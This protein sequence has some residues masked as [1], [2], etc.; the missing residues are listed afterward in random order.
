MF[1]AFLFI[2]LPYVAILALIVGTAYRAHKHRFTNTALTSQFLESRSLMWGAVA[3]HAG[4][5]VVLAGHAVAILMPDLWLALTSNYAFLVTV[6]VIGIAAAMLALAGLCVL[7]V[8]RVLHARL[9]RVS[10]VMDFAV[11]GLLIAQVLLGLAVAVSYRWGAVWS[12]QTAT[13]YLWSLVRL[14]PDLA[15]AAAMPPVMKLHL[16]GAF[17]ILLMIPFT[18]LVHMFFFPIGY[19]MRAPQRVIWATRRRFE[20]NVAVQQAE[21]SRR[22]FLK[23]AT[24]LSAAGVLLS[25]GVFD[26][27][28]RFFRGTAMAAEDEAELL[29]KKLNRLEQAASERELELERLRSEYIFVANLNALSRTEGAY[30]T[31]YQMRPALAFQDDD[32]LPLLISAKCTHLGCTV[33]STLDSQG[34]ILCPCHISYFDVKTGQPNAGAPAKAPLPHLGWVLMDA[35]GTVVASKNPLGRLEGTVDMAKLSE[36]RVYIAKKF[37]GLA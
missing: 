20:R 37:G 32:G 13:P 5:F 21:E 35:G 19:V 22:Y 25:L 16:A 23:T 1:D 3:W 29:R 10:T 6:E 14:Q 2:G 11:L 24:G 28:F 18:R 8:R 27:L 30:F 4:I 36:Y 7:F 15:L 34:R 12:T 26:K 33:A 9:Q 31:D 17:V